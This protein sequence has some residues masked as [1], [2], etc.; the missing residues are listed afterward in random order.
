MPQELVV[1]VDC[2]SHHH[3]FLKKTFIFSHWPLLHSLL[4]NIR[5]YV[6]TNISQTCVKLCV[7]GYSSCFLWCTLS[8]PKDW[9][10][11][12]MADDTSKSRFC[13]H[14]G[15]LAW[16]GSK[17][18]TFCRSWSWLGNPHLCNA[19]TIDWAPR[20]L[21]SY[22]MVWSLG[23]LKTA[24]NQLYTT[25]LMHMYESVYRWT[26]G[27]ISNVQSDSLINNG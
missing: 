5:L 6:L 11:L 7:I 12:T 4:L 15:N 2:D 18:S 25:I 22:H 14:L 8:V 23:T 9:C 16:R 1:I 24:T 17:Q 13:L 26:C 20:D 27:Y 3:C 19:W 10:F 21:T